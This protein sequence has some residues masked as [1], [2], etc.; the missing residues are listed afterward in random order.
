MKFK[1]PT[2]AAV[3][4]AVS[5]FAF[6]EAEPP[7]TEVLVEHEWL[8]QYV[9]EWEV[10]SEM[11]MEPGAEA[12]EMKSTESVRPI[13][14]LWVL[15]EGSADS[16]G[17]A[18]KSVLTLGYD[19]EKEAF[20]GTWIDSATPYLWTF[21]GQIDDAKKVLTLET[22]GPRWGE[23]GTSAKYREQHVFVDA[24]HRTTSS[25]IQKEDGSWFTFLRTDCR[26]KE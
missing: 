21:T 26:R 3:S 1:I 2:L 7:A 4:L 16:D 15:D 14:P 13:G 11:R 22:E 18:F 25:S 8:H 10:T 23:M 20:V 24:N 6:Q 5:A 9:G 17:V 19:P 12:T